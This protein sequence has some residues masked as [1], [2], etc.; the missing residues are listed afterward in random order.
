M[1][2]T[3]WIAAFAVCSWI[4]VQQGGTALG[5]V[6]IAPYVN[7]HLATITKLFDMNPVVETYTLNIRTDLT[8]IARCGIAILDKINEIREFATICTTQACQ[9]ELEVIEHE[10]E[11][12][13]YH[14]KAI[15]NTAVSRQK[16]FWE[17]GATWMRTN[18]GTLNEEDLEALTEIEANLRR[19]QKE[20]VSQV[21]SGKQL[22]VDSFEHLK[23]VAQTINNISA[24]TEERMNE[25][26][27]ELANA[28]QDKATLTALGEAARR[29]T[30]AAAGCI[31]L[32]VSKRIGGKMLSIFKVDQIY[33]E[34]KDHLAPGTSVAID[35]ILELSLQ[36]EAS[37]S[38]RGN[39]MITSL[40]IPVITED[41]WEVFQ[42][43]QKPML[44]GDKIIMLHLEQSTFAL[45]PRN[46]SSQLNIPQECYSTNSNRRAC[47]IQQPMR[48]SRD[49][50][51]SL[52]TSRHSNAIECRNNVVAAQ[53]TTDMVVRLDQARVLV[54]PKSFTNI[55]VDCLHQ[56][57]FQVV[58][59]RPSVVEVTR[60][61][62]LQINDMLFLEAPI[63]FKDVNVEAETP[64]MIDLAV[65]Q[66]LADAPPFP[67]MNQ[68][69]LESLDQLG[70]KIKQLNEKDLETPF[71]HKMFTRPTTSHKAVG[72]SCGVAAAAA[73]SIYIYCRCRAAC[74]CCWCC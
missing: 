12:G 39:V 2:G 70:L 67:R 27:K 6:E 21:A 68:T 46:Y 9:Q 22:L 63:R 49:C 73:I 15:K 30:T 65:H 28:E 51:S 4:L 8:H 33:N 44:V 14:L 34:L 47:R 11:Q 32:L 58:I 10:V 37:I 42:I 71:L 69:Q 24:V 16:R 57:K 48:C 64:I 53:I 54:I 59:D 7:E 19:Q 66:H 13:A 1:T 56:W 25:I 41:R 50:A 23:V 35:S 29:F 26:K 60:P 45:T 20:V 18:L 5:P 36:R 31:D 38:I 74:C 17:F 72:I 40:D 3:A 52:I 55:S 61:C 62:S 43:T